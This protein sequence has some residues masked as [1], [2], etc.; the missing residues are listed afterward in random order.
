MPH[1]VQHRLALRGTEEAGEDTWDCAPHPLRGALSALG[2][3]TP[4]LGWVRAGI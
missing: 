3:V 2:A 1:G 4:A